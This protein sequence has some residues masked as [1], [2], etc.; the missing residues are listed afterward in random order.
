[1]R[2]IAC[3]CARP[4]TGACSPAGTVVVR[5]ATVMPT[6][7]VSW[8]ADYAPRAER[9]QHHCRQQHQH[10]YHDTQALA[11]REA[12]S[13]CHNSSDELIH[14][15][16]SHS[17][18]QHTKALA[19]TVSSSGMASQWTVARYIGLS[20]GLSM[21]KETGATCTQTRSTRWRKGGYLLSCIGAGPQSHRPPSRA[22]D[23]GMGSSPSQPQPVGRPQRAETTSHLAGRLPRILWT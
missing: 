6:V 4:Y 17:P 8:P 9:G 20:G 3:Q 19:C 21:G 10:S 16:K 5:R 14:H 18:V 12:R 7:L 2:I 11:M 22:P 1:M 15:N 13:L 23:S